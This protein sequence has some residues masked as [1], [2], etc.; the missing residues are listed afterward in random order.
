[1]KESTPS[2]LPTGPPLNLFINE[3]CFNYNDNRKEQ[4]PGEKLGLLYD[5]AALYMLDAATRRSRI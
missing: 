5:S 1:M 3:E 2:P 4:V